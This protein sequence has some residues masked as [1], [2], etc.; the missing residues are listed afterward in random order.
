[1][2]TRLDRVERQCVF[3]AAD[4]ATIAYCAPRFWPEQVIDIVDPTTCAVLTQQIRDRMNTQPDGQ[5]GQQLWE[6]Q[7]SAVRRSCEEDRWTTGFAQC[8]STMQSASYVVPYCQHIAPAPLLTRLQD[9][10]AKVK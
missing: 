1:M 5:P 4:A 2:K 6:R 3:E 7:L 9:R 10:L 8:A